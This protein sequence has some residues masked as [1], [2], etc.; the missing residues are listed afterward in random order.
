[1]ALSQQQQMQ[2]IRRAASR[3][4]IKPSVLW[5]LYGV[6]TSYGRNVGPS[7]AGAV[8]PFQF[9][10]GTA[11]SLG[12]NPLNFRQAANGAARY[13]AQ[14]KSRGVRGM[15]AAYN[16]G[17]N[18]NPS[19]AG[20]YPTDVLR[21]ARTWQGGGRVPGLDGGGGQTTV[22]LGSSQPGTVPQGSEG[23][24]SLVQQL[25]AKPP[26][27]Q[28]AGL[29]APSFAA[30]VPLPQGYQA[31]QGGGGPAPK[32]DTAALL[33]AIKTIGADVPGA[34]GSGGVSVTSGAPGAAGGAHGASAA[35]HA[36]FDGKRVRADFAQELAWAR[37]H[38]WQGTV[39][40]GYRNP[41][42]QMAAAKRYGLQHY[43]PAGPLGSNHV[44]NR[45]VDVTDPAQLDKILRRYPGKRTLIWGGPI[46]G[47]APHFSVNGH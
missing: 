25:T 39:T 19:A 42:E 45:A 32:P 28:S 22:D 11:R 12:I 31:P 38:G 17:P 15:L 47:D 27:P 36:M 14:Y 37:R 40:S 26:Q 44:K 34:T 6:E 46:I 13:L 21:A 23:I 1:M 5:G 18:A 35:G 10:P 33:A 41:Q 3:A 9:L 7:S 20:S 29:Q 16:A 8:G 4:G 2:I 24:L 43:G 30:S